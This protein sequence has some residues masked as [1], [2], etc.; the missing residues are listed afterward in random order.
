MVAFAGLAD[1]E[2]FFASLRQVGCE[3]IR[4]VEFKDHHRY[5]PSDI[6]ELVESA[7]RLGV[8]CL[9]TTTKDDV[10]IDR[11]KS[12]PIEWVVV[13]V[14]IGMPMDGERFRQFLMQ[15]L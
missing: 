12:L 2:Q 11:P 14:Q 1:N 15:S 9:V 4:R 5:T 3:I 8:D 13:D 10:K 6:H 7:I